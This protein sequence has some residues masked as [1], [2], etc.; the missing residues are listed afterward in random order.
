MGTEGKGCLFTLSALRKDSYFSRSQLMEK[1]NVFMFL[2]VKSP[3]R[4]CIQE[5]SILRPNN[6]NIASH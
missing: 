5:K 6:R 4:G 2:V 1:K 3:R